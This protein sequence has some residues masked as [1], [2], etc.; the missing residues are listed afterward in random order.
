LQV[1]TDNCRLYDRVWGSP[2]GLT[3]L[4]I[5]VIYDESNSLSVRK[6][7]TV[8]REHRP[9]V[10]TL[11]PNILNSILC[12]LDYSLKEAAKHLELIVSG[13]AVLEDS[14]RNQAQ[15]LLGVKV[16]NTYGLSEM[17][18]VASECNVY[19]GM[20]LYECNTISEI[21]TE[22]NEI[23]QDGYGELILSHTANPGMPLLRYRTGDLVNLV[24]KPCVCGKS[25]RRIKQVQGR[26]IK[27]FTLSNGLEIS[28]AKFSEVFT[29]FPIREF[30][31]TQTSLSH[32]KVE[33]EF[34][35]DYERSDH[36]AMIQK[37]FEREFQFLVN[38]EL[39]T[40]IF[41]TDSKFQRYRTL[42]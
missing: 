35:R 38:V 5:R 36:L 6:L 29:I 42:I 15:E 24:S 2:A 11:K 16:C 1:A 26:V 33:M 37:Y 31:M 9:A 3:G 30:R 14:L 39:V 13:G 10:L 34:T 32:L 40:V 21:L 12:N 41:P 18:I 4:T 25:G 17:G 27:N 19:D 7:T 20:H 23:L 28:P 8:L 22:Q